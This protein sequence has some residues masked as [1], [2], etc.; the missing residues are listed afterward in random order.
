MQFLSRILGSLTQDKRGLDLATIAAVERAGADLNVPRETRHYLY[1]ATQ[2]DARHAAEELARPYRQVTVQPA[3]TGRKWLA[4]VVQQV[5]VDI[6]SI[7]ELRRE[8]EAATAL[9]GGDYDGWEAAIHERA[10]KPG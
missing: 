9:P 6:D 8:F 2:E 7:S 5:R 1:F 4:E 10:S 3:A